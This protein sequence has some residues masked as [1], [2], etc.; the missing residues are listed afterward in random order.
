MKTAMAASV[1]NQASFLK[2]L[3]SISLSGKRH[4]PLT[5]AVFVHPL[6]YG[7]P[8]AHLVLSLP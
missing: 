7:L 2:K 6:F 4:L 8:S 1:G 3:D 5:P